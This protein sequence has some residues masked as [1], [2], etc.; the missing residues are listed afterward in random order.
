MNLFEKLKNWWAGYPFDPYQR[1][2]DLQSGK[3]YSRKIVPLKP[4]EVNRPSMTPMEDVG[5]GFRLET[6]EELRNRILSDKQ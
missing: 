3:A 5:F 4:G 1:L 2:D 6:D